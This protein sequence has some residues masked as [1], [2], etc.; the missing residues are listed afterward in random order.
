MAVVG[1]IAAAVLLAGGVVLLARRT[2][3][4]R[5]AHGIGV[6]VVRSWLAI[7]LVIGLL[8]FCGVAFAIYDPGLRSTLIGAL[9]ASVGSVTTFYFASKA[10]DQA[11]QDILNA[12]LGTEAVPDLSGASEAGAAATMSRTSLKLVNDPQALP[13]DNAPHVSSQEPR[14]DTEVPKG[15][16]VTVSFGP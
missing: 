4:D 11:R 14:K 3:S 9:T 13:T 15:S 10:S 8:M 7:T 2:T 16:T 6:S 12:A 5:Q 1:I